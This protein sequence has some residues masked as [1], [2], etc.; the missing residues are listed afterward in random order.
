MKRIKDK[1][2]LGILI[3][4]LA[5]AI[6]LFGYYLVKF[7]PT[8]SLGEYFGAIIENKSVLTAVSSISLL[9]NVVIFT[10]LINR[11]IDQTAK[12]VFL[13][14]CIYILAVIFYKLM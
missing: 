2:K 4:L 1:L 11:K 8:F 13:I 3:G 5:P 7:F 10:Y 9:A 14:T 6:G 12:G